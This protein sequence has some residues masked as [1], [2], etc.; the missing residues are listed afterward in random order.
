MH[1]IASKGHPPRKKNEL[2]P[3]REWDARVKDNSVYHLVMTNISIHFP[4]PMACHHPAAQKTP[5]RLSPEGI[6][7]LFLSIPLFSLLLSHE[8][9]FLHDLHMSSLFWS[10]RLSLGAKNLLRNTKE[11][12]FSPHPSHYCA[13]CFIV[14][15][16]AIF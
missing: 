5:G 1:S 12:H 13:I 16:L 2:G 8:S 10:A 3:V 15:I 7:C 6:M 4:D 9:L 11:S 14:L